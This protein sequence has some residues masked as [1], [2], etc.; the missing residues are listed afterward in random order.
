MLKLDPIHVFPL[1]IF[2][3]PASFIEPTLVTEDTREL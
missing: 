3:T 2:L 1:D